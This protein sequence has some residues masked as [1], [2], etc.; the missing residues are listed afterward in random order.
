MYGISKKLWED[1]INHIRKIDINQIQPD[2]NLSSNEIQNPL[3][4][5]YIPFNSW[6]NKFQI[7]KLAIYPIFIL[8]TIVWQK[9]GFLWSIPCWIFFYYRNWDRI[10]TEYM[11]FVTSRVSLS[12]KDLILFENTN[13]YTF[14]VRLEDLI[15]EIDKS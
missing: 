5:R 11:G 2:L 9:F 13:T 3:F 15:I 6:M 14:A 7:K 12:G 10:R 4:A 1:I 8:S